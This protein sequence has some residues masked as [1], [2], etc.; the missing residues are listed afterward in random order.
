MSELPLFAD[1]WNKNKEKEEGSCTHYMTKDT[2]LENI[3]FLP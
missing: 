1:K 3:T 2:D